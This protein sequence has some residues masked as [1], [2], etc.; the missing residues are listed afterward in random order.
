VAVLNFNKMDKEIIE[1]YYQENEE[2]LRKTAIKEKSLYKPENWW[3]FYLILKEETAED[4]LKILEYIKETL[5]KMSSSSL[6]HAALDLLISEK[7]SQEEAF[8]REMIL[9]H[10]NRLKGKLRT[11]TISSLYACTELGERIAKI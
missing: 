10:L 2:I 11:Q 6:P 1:L 4:K 8:A 9:T 7:D 3:Y 5:K